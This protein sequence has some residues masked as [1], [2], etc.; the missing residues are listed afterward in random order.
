MLVMCWYGSHSYLDEYIK[1]NKSKRIME[2]GVYNGENAVSMVK[3]AFENHPPEQVEY[4][5]FDFF[6]NYTTEQIAEKLDKL[7]CKHKLIQG[8]TLETVPKASETLPEMDLIFIDGGK[9]Y[10]EAWSDWQGSSKLMHR[11]TAVYVHNA[12]FTGVNKMIEA[13]PTTEYNIESFHPHFEGKVAL[14][15]RKE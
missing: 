12:G 8:N 1:E 9:S 2:I 5:G 10:Q 7:G 11:D 4:Y 13:I 3:A 15:K 6:Y 14:I